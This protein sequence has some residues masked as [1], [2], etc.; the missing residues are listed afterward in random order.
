MIGKSPQ[1]PESLSASPPPPLPPPASRRLGGDLD[2]SPERGIQVRDLAGGARGGGPPDDAAP[3][4]GE[5][6]RGLPPR[7]ALGGPVPDAVAPAQPD[8]GPDGGGAHGVPVAGE[9]QAPGGVGVAA[10]VDDEV[11][12]PGAAA[13]ERGPRVG[14]ALGRV[15]DGHAAD[16]RVVLGG[17]GGQVA[18]GL[19][20]DLRG[21]FLCVSDLFLLFFSVLFWGRACGSVEG[22]ACLRTA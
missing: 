14:G 6:A 13:D 16:L 7:A 10:L 8:G 19:L 21:G 4:D 1:G 5:G 11:D 17:E 15:A 3:V 2:Q 9:A 12:V 22:S 20:G 18:E